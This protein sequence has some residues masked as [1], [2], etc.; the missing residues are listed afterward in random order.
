MDDTDAIALSAS[1][2]EE[3]TAGVLV[4]SAGGI[5]AALVDLVAGTCHLV[6]LGQQ[7]RKD[8]A[9]LHFANR[10]NCMKIV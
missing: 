1:A 7:S 3:A 9:A 4:V 10:R 6:V 8:D 5:L 2:D